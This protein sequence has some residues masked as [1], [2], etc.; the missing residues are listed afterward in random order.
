MVIKQILEE[1]IKY[2]LQIEVIEEAFKYSKE[3]PSATLEECL[4]V[5]YR[6]WIK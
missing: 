5:G 3:E 2:E 1:A 6:E 4:M